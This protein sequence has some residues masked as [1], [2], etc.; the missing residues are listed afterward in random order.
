M[1]M[2]KFTLYDNPRLLLNMNTCTKFL[3]VI[4][5]MMITPVPPSTLAA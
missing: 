1:L 2:S 5:M 4:P 3:P